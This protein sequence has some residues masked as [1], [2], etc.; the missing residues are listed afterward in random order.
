MVGAQ[1]LLLDLQGPLVSPFGLA[2]LA[3]RLIERR[4][5]VKVDGDF[6]TV[7]TIDTLENRKRAKL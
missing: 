2:Q 7:R 1:E 6:V 4:Q 3:L 5:I